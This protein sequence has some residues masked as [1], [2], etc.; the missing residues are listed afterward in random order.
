MLTFFFEISKIRDADFLSEKEQGRTNF[1]KLANEKNKLLE[2]CA[3]F[4]IWREK[5][6]F[7]VKRKKY[8]RTCNSRGRNLLDLYDY[9]KRFETQI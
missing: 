9:S 7:R 6:F 2:T 8:D 4:E 1:E 3:C 5:I